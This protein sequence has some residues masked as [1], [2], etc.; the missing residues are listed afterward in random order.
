MNLCPLCKSI[1]DKK[2]SIINYD[3]K[4]YM[5]NK[6]NSLFTRY[7]KKCN[8]DICLSCSYEHKNHKIETYSYKFIDIKKLRK[9]MNEFENV[10]NK[11]KTNLNKFKK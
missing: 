6:H 3:N 8:L 10:I 11:L 1:H 9:K 2:H 7:C 5:C 4:N